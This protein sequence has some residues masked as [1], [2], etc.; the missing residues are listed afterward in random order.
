MLRL[1]C[2]ALSL[3]VIAAPASAEAAAS[4][5][6]PFVLV[7]DTSGAISESQNT[8]RQNRPVRPQ[9]YICVVDQSSS[10]GG[11]GQVSCPANPGRVGGRCRCANVTGSGTLLTY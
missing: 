5:S 7:N 4:S 2:V 9:R 1:F 3:L 10:V 11:G 6:L 8:P